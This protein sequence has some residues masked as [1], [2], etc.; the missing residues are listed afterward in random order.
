MQSNSADSGWELTRRD[1]LRFGSAVAIAGP[2]SRIPAAEA[3][4]PVLRFGM[5]TDCHFADAEPLGT[6][7]YRDSLP[8]VAEAVE[9]MNS[10]DLAFALENGDFKDQSLKPSA[11]QTLSYLSQIEAEFARF[12]GPRYHVLGNHDMDSISKSQF[13]SV[14]ENT[15]IPKE[16]TFYSFNAKGTHIVAL[17]ACFASKDAAYDSGNFDWKD[18]N[19]PATQLDW[20]K[21]DLAAQSMPTIVFIHQRLDGEGSLYVKNAASVRSILESQGN[22]LA[23]FQGH[24]HPGGHSHIKNIHYYTLRAV[25]EGAGMDNNAFATVDLDASGSLT[26]NGYKKAAGMALPAKL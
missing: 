3:E 17:D 1:F 20:L 18:A 22:V 6:R 14:V 23:V 12:K 24:D 16:Q 2:L 26:V 7:A 8:K 21:A 13:Q 10:Q 25:V 15:G 4:S 5:F 11:E 9:F 19:V